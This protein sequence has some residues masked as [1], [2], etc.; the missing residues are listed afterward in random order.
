MLVLTLQRSDCMVQS[1]DP[2]G[3]LVQSDGHAGHSVFLFIF[4]AVFFNP[5]F[6]AFLTPAPTAAVSFYFRP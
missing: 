5:Q 2:I 1:K 4:A 6:G 3:S